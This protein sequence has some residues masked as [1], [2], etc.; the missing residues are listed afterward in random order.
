MIGIYCIN[1]LY[2]NKRY[3]GKSINIEDR[4]KYH[5]KKL[6]KGKHNN[7]HLQKAWEIYGEKNFGFSI[8]Q[9]CSENNL[10]NLE[11]YWSTFYNTENPEFGYNIRETGRGARHSKETKEK[12]RIA[13]IGKPFSDKHKENL[14]KNHADFSGKNSCW[15][16]KSFS[17]EHKRKLS[18]NH[19]NFS[20]INS[21]SLCKKYPNASS[22]Y[23]G[24]SFNKNSKKWIACVYYNNSRNFLGYFDNEY[25]AAL[26][27]D[28]YIIKNRLN[29]PLNFQEVGNVSI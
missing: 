19:A 23:Y 1:N 16:G 3:I 28:N 2:N 17:D 29:Y 25:D 14:S 5:K 18:E 26:S 15:F 13:K 10:N 21:P 9:E 4:W 27:R 11:K 12:M 24:V 20:G 6:K 7:S 22:K 8:I